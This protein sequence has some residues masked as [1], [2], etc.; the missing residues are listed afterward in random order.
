MTNSEPYPN[1]DPRFGDPV[2]VGTPPRGPDHGDDRRWTRIW[3]VRVACTL[4]HIVCGLF[5]VVLLA[6]ILLVIGDAN[7]ANGIARFVRGW[8]GAVSLGFE[9][10]F[11]PEGAGARAAINYGLAALAWVGIS[12]LVTTLIRRFALPARDQD[13]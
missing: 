9:D 10:L 2:P 11:T 6:H 8:S 12:A 3:K 13:A 4:V 5:A 7:P 1:S